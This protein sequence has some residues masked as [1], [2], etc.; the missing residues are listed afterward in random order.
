M[1]AK[2]PVEEI[3]INTA[4]VRVVLKGVRDRPGMAAEIFQILADKGINIE[5]IVSGPSSRG[6]TDIAF[7]ILESQLPRLQ[8]V[9]EEILKE[10]I[11]QDIQI[12]PKVALI[13]F[14]GT[15]EMQ[16]TPGVASTILNALAMAGVNVEMFS[17]SVDSVS[18]VIRED[19]VDDAREAIVEAF[20]IEPEPTYG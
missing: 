9:S 14:Y 17:A 2:I 6:R 4:V 13:I 1:S 5:M 3:Y 11:A 20:G 16:R 7:L 12:D 19:R 15:R 10:S 8:E 18:L